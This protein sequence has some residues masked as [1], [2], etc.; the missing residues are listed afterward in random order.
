MNIQ[1]L[2]H[3]TIVRLDVSIWSGRAKLRK[4]DLSG[5]IRNELPPEDVVTLGSKRLYNPSALKIFNTL[6]ARA[7]STLDKK[8]VRFLGGWATHEDR[9]PDLVVELSSIASEFK[10]AQDKFLRSYGESAVSWANNFPKYREALLNAVPP[11]NEVSNKFSFHW[12]M[13]KITPTTVGDGTYLGDNLISSVEHIE[14]TLLQEVARSITEIYKEC[15]DGRTVVTK[16]A[17]RPVRTLIDKVHGLTFMHPN[18]EGLEQILQE[19][20]DI[21]EDNASDEKH[22]AMFKNFLLSMQSAEAIV[23]VCVP[24]VGGVTSLGGVFDQF[25]TVAIPQVSKTILLPPGWEQ[26]NRGVM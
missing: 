18:I 7:A 21:V 1:N 13:F 9:L 20:V 10:D 22:V 14:D 23:K 6:K 3:L 12:Q 24:Y 5:T 8:A 4:D 11:V 15:F 16:K 25:W 19:A 17:F 26:F 2:N